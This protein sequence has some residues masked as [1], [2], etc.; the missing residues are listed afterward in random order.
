MRKFA[1]LLVGVSFLALAATT[2]IAGQA[3][4]GQAGGRQGGAGG[5]DLARLVVEACHQPSDF[6]PL[7]ALEDTLKDKMDA[8]A[9]RVYGAAGVEYQPSAT[10]RIKELEKL[11]FGKLPICVAKTQNSLSDNAKAIGRPKGFWVFVRDVK[12]SAGAGFVVFY[13]GNILTMPGLPKAPAAIKMGLD[14]E[15]KVVGLS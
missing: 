6:H 14:A 11:G 10:R 15:G 8:I 9:W 1:F 2:H 13:A 12:V 4:G 7:Y 3:S 5:A